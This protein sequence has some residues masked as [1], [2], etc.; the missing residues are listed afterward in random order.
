MERIKA[1]T[2]VVL[3]R[4]EG[5]IPDEHK[6]AMGNGQGWYIFNAARPM[7][8]HIAWTGDFIR[9]IFYG[10]IDPKQECAAEYIKRCVELNGY[11]L[12]FA[13]ESEVREQVQRYYDNHFKDEKIDASEYDLRDLWPTYVRHIK[14]P[15]VQIQI[16]CRAIY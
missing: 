14:A 16:G 15:E 12:A 2:R 4:R 1:N 8:C 13:E 7:P 11:V 6:E 10:A 9:G 5:F 3:G